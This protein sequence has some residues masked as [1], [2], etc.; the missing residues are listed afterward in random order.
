MAGAPALERPDLQWHS[1]CCQPDREE[2]RTL[3]C[4]TVFKNYD[5]QLST[6][7]DFTLWPLFGHF[8]ISDISFDLFSLFDQLSHFLRKPVPLM[9]AAHRVS[10]ARS[11]LRP[12]EG[13]QQGQ[14]WCSVP[15][16]W[17]WKVIQASLEDGTEGELGVRDVRFARELS[18]PV[19]VD[20]LVGVGGIQSSDRAGVTGFPR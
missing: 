3:P 2:Q 10:N 13:S 14:Q 7:T 1:Q 19:W 9:K 18:V 12:R 16:G 6:C 8:T 15:Y 17:I 5:A 11:S 20:R 4:E